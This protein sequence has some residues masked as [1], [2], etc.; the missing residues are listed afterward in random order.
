MLGRRTQDGRALLNHERA[1]LALAD[2]TEWGQDD[3]S[4]V[5]LYPELVKQAREVEMTSFRKMEVYTQLPKAMQ[6]MKVERSS[7]TLGGSEQGRLR[8]PRHEKSSR[9]ARVQHRQE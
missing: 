8:K 2:G 5:E 4:G 7:G 1:K 9:R 6:R 3:A